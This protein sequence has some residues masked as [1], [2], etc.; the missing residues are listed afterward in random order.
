MFLKKVCMRREYVNIND[1]NSNNNNNNNNNNS[2]YI[3]K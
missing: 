2:K 3:K 1:N